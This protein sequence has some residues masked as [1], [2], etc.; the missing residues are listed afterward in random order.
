MIAAIGQG[1]AILAACLYGAL[2]L[3]L[4]RHWRTEKNSHPLAAAFAIM[5]AWMAFVA[6]RSPADILPGLAE[7]ARNIAFLAFMHR[8]AA[9][10]TDER[11]RALK[12]VYGA[13]AAVAG[14]QLLITCLLPITRVPEPA[15]L[16][17][18]QGL[19]LTFSA[20]AL[21]LVHNLYVQASPE[22]RQAIRLPLL[23]LTAMW[24]YD[25][26]LYT[27][28]YLT[29]ALPEDLSALRA[30]ML[31]LLVPFFAVAGRRETWR[32]ELSRT[33]TFQ[34]ISLL[35]LFAYLI[36]MMSA[37]R[38][39]EALGAKWVDTAQGAILILITA[40]LLFLLPFRRARAWLRVK[41]A[42]HLFQHRYDY[43]AE[44]L[45]FTRTIGAGGEE[46]L[47]IDVRVVKALAQIAE[48]Q[49][50]LMLT[51][52]GG[53]FI[54]TARWNWTGECGAFDDPAFVR[55]IG[56]RAY[57]VDFGMAKDGQLTIDEA[58]IPLPVW[59]RTVDIWA[60]IPLLHN[61]RLIG[62]VLLAAPPVRRRIDWEDI[63][64]F[65]TAGIE[66]AS[67]LAEARA[68]EDL[69]DA[70]KFDEFSRR[71]A[72]IMHDIKNLVSQI[73]LVARNAERHADNPEFR[74][75]M[76]A[77]LQGSV[78][79]MND[80]L[81]RLSRGAQGEVQPPRAITLHSVLA[82]IAEAKARAHPVELEGALDVVALADAPGLEQAVIHIVQNAIDASA[83]GA[84]VRIILG[85][86]GGAV[87]IAIVDEGAG[88]SA[89]FI[90]T[91]LFQPFA[92]TKEAGFGIGA[93]EARSLVEAMAGR[94]EVESREGAG[95]T[96]T[97]T[98]PSGRLPA[99]SQA[100][101]ISA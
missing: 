49:G 97:I 20:G 92:S 33:A 67:Y 5:S 12:T 61:D 72:F 27:V 3:W 57:V 99:F 60:G 85:E 96:F 17:A 19:G 13:V 2:T 81:A 30:A 36:I 84:P 87:T 55:A 91:R 48:A 22:S 90:R 14:G 42:K 54:P 10:R 43:R 11:Q 88:M 65:R 4:L 86:K 89:D 8:I 46:A 35:A 73:S 75:D 62:L 50:G 31:V 79:K 40:T 69:A 39:L 6:N 76:I 24:T 26:H 82:P 56:P 18:W 28:A 47:P 101:R 32:V 64:L 95:T 1:S 52:E 77:T 44:W 38:A 16:A 29:R 68:Q 94:L 34:T 59:M 41:T 98:L 58:A 7:A 70:R 45:R 53:R 66:A 23:G 15:I 25:L 83:E 78:K 93:Y 74:A 51:I 21:I 63:D 100:E 37:T 9:G 71:F 80:L